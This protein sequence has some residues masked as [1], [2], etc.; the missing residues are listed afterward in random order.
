M[1]SRFT[2]KYP[3]GDLFNKSSIQEDHLF[4][5]GGLGIT[6][7]LGLIEYFK[8]LDLTNK[9]TLFYSA[10]YM[11]EIIHFRDLEK[12]LGDNLEVFLTKENNNQ[13][14]SNR[15]TLKDIERVANQ[16]TNIYV[17]GSVSF[18]SDFKELLLTN[19]YSKLH[20]DEWE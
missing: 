17:C 16:N 18:N 11:S 4:L 6:P 20:M 5:A 9:I 12:Y 1:G 14:H 3:F 19:G 7:F 13:Y 10:K 8:S 15:I 2:I